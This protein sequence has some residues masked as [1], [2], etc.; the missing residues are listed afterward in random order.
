MGKPRRPQLITTSAT[1]GRAA[2]TFWQLWQAHPKNAQ[3]K[4]HILH[5]EPDA[6]HRVSAFR[7][8]RVPVRS[9]R[10]LVRGCCSCRA[11]SSSASLLRPSAIAR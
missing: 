11:S 4:G 9:P 8:R 3:V 6:D 5:P 7:G 1:T 10:A 2:P